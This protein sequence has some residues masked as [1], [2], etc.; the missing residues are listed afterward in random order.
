MHIPDGYLGPQTYL[1]TYAV[2]A[3]CWALASTKLKRALRLRQVPLLALGAAFSFVIMMFNLPI[4]GGTSGHAVGAVLVAVVLGP[5]AA[6]IAVSLALIL[7]ALLFGDG[8]LT[9][10]GANC[11]TMAVI[12][13]VVGWSIYRLVSGGAAARSP[14]HWLGAA[15]GGYFGL[16]AAAVSAGVLLGLQPLLARDA[17]GHALYCPFGLHIA[18]PV[19]ALEHLLV[20]GWV[21]AAATGLVVAYLQRTA[22]ELLPY[23]AS[24]E[25]PRTQRAVMK[26]LAIGLGVL[27]LLSP[28]GLYLPKALHAGPAWGEWGSA[29]IRQEVARETGGQGYVP[30]GLARAEKS[31]RRPPLPGYALPGQGSAPLRA[32]SFSYI[33]SGVIGAA[34][35]VLLTLATRRAW[36][37]KDEGGT[38][39][40]DAHS[41]QA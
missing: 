32:L 3:G 19:M 40:V 31:G 22:P 5:W 23:A 26:R 13:P 33:L 12:M 24:P 20:F 2:A 14:R 16:T 28:L 15:L 30:T 29:E 27:V 37:R 21:E 18:V 38:A 11:L 8:G 9:A 25:A 34:G 7:Q 17:A 35:L 1:P 39:G 36:A 41:G 10:I 4:P 6:I